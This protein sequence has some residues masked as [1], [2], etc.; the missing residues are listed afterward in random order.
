M[1]DQRTGMMLYGVNAVITDYPDGMQ[2]LLQDRSQA[3]RWYIDKNSNHYVKW[4]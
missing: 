4:C 2:Q 3:S 1:D